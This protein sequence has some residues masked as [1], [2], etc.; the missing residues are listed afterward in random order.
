MGG[1]KEVTAQVLYAALIALELLSSV[2]LFG[3]ALCG[4]NNS[5]NRCKSVSNRRRFE[6]TKSISNAT[7]RIANV[8]KDLGDFMLARGAAC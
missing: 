4:S 3:C 1:K 5:V 2:A 7:I 6:K 8:R